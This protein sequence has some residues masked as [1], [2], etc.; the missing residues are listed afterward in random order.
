MVLRH[1]NIGQHTTGFVY[2]WTRPVQCAKRVRPERTNSLARIA[3]TIA[4]LPFNICN[5]FKTTHNGTLHTRVPF[6]YVAMGNGTC[7][8]SCSQHPTE[9]IP[10]PD[11]TGIGISLAFTITAGLALCIVVAYYSI[12]Y[13]PDANPFKSSTKKRHSRNDLDLKQNPIDLY[14][15]HWRLKTGLE[16]ANV[17]PYIAT[18]ALSTVRKRRTREALTQCM[19][20][21][22]DFQLI[23]GLSVLISGY[24]QLPCGIPNI[25]WERI[26]DLAWF[27]CITHLCC[28]TFLRNYFCQNQGA[29]FWRVPGMVLLVTLLSLAYIPSAAYVEWNVDLYNPSADYAI[30]FYKDMPEDQTRRLYSSHNYNEIS[31][32]LRRTVVSAIVLVFGMTNRIWSLYETSMNA[33]LTVRQWSRR[34]VKKVLRWA[35]ANTK[36][37]SVFVVGLTYRPILAVY[38][39]CSILVNIITSKAFEVW[40]LIL[41]LAWGLTNLYPLPKMIYDQQWTFGQVIALLLLIAPIIALVDTYITTVYY[42]TPESDTTI[43]HPANTSVSSVLPPSA[44]TLLQNSP[45]LLAKDDPDHDF[46]NASGSFTAIVWIMIVRVAVLSVELLASKMIFRHNFRPIMVLYAVSAT[47]NFFFSINV[48][49]FVLCSLSVDQH[50]PHNK[51]ART[52]IVTLT[53]LFYSGIMVLATILSVDLIIYPPIVYALLL[54]L[55]FF[56]T[57]RRSAISATTRSSHTSESAV[58]LNSVSTMDTSGSAANSH[59]PS[60]PAASVIRSSM[61]LPAIDT[62]Y[63]FKPPTR[64]D[65]EADI[66]I[67]SPRRIWQNDV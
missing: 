56:L 65:T 28:L 39:L 42:A 6:A 55:E 45:R 2:Q 52:V 7:T 33:Y 32:K 21:M 59:L 40:W 62:S 27:S 66:G 26:T 57:W 30:C 41:A 60:E 58:C 50:M 25:H 24:S 3:G 51:I 54:I 31:S 10:N 47:P 36:T 8:Y 29:R 14:F 46:Y 34:Q 37:R 13:L 38:L 1:F 19:L 49:L 15:L 5:I 23:T 20:T 53:F 17:D 64:Q 22:S 12:A 48:A 63:A 9:S 67:L 18:Q 11:I 43:E 16:K 35:Y 61:R 4:A 44:P